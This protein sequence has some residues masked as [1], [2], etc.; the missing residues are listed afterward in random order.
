[1]SL[2]FLPMV[3]GSEYVLPATTS[4]TTTESIDIAATPH[5]VWLSIVH[6]GAIKS[7]IS[8]PFQLGVAYPVRG[9]IIGEGVG[10]IR[11]GT[12]STGIALER[13]TEWSV[14]H[15]LAFVV[16]SDPPAMH[17]LSPYQHVNAPHVKGY[18]RTSYT[19]FAIIPLG[20]GRC[21]VVEN[22]RHELK[23]D[24]V[25][26]WMPFARWIIHDNNMRVLSHI[27]HQSEAMHVAI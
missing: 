6:M 7:P 8:L 11:K 22:T 13:V 2:A 20:N 25:L 18:F 17:E 10:A 19:S 3:F 27:Q 12:F 21:R 1:M 16:V 24:P 5:D 15:K 14:D 9:D 23:L 4:F 26:Y